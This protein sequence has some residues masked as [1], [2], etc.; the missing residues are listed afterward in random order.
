[1]N[2]GSSTVTNGLVF[3]YDQD[4]IKSYRG[5]VTTNLLNQITANASDNGSTYRF[6]AGTEDVYIPSVGNVTSKYVD[7]YNDYNGGSG[8]CCPNPYTF[9]SPSVSG[10]T[11]YTYAILYKSANRYTHP[12]Y[13]Y[14]YEYG[15]SGYLTEYGLF[16]T[17]GSY[18][19]SERHLGD[20]W[21]WAS[22]KFTTNAA[23]T[24]F[25]CYAFMYQYA[26]WNR[27][28]V[29]KV[30]LAQGNHL[31]LHPKYWPDVGQS[32]T[33]SQVCLNAINNSSLTFE[34]NSFNN[35]GSLNFN[36]SSYLSAG[37]YG[38]QFSNYT[39][40]VVFKSDSVS[41]YRNPIDCNW[42][43]YNGSYSNIGPRLEQNNYGNL[44]WIVGDTSGNYENVNVVASG[45]SSTPYHVVTLTKTGSTLTAYYNGN[46]TE[47]KI[48]AYQ[49]PGYFNN[50]NLGRGFSADSERYFIG[51]IPATYVYNRALTPAEVKHNFNALRGR[52]GL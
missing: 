42:L 27:F 33:S 36:G 3:A 20:G 47:T 28:Y 37:N 31:N 40:T 35:D 51:K 46:V 41:S 34:N 49:H 29:A 25:N 17:D 32:R 45:L 26:T 23:A 6:F 38:S 9:G 24:Y 13:M 30:L 52:Y 15:A 43:I 1:M 22:S 21:Y 10:G 2:I 48:N 11:E 5:P 12:N 39:V 8:N 16:Y 44:V 18:S 14:H 7:M 19:G 4:N 50:I